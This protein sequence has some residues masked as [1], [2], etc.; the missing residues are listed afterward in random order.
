MDV[1]E[2]LGGFPLAITQM[3]GVITRLDLTFAEFLRTYDEEESRA[4]LLGLQLEHPSHR[5]G[6]EHTIASAWAI[7][8][9]SSRSGAFGSTIFVR[10]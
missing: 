1:A 5:A 7:E 3:A 4:E 9:S 10:S 6:Y 8:K 2:H